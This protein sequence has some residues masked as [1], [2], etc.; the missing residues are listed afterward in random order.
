M[1]HQEILEKAWEECLAS[2][3]TEEEEPGE[4][5]VEAFRRIWERANK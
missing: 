2:K 5:F 3:K 1:I 4:P